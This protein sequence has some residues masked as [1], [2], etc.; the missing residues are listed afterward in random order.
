M[1]KAELLFTVL[2]LAFST[3]TECLAAE[4][5]ELTHSLYINELMQSTWGGE[6]DA[7]NEYPD[8]WVEL[9]NPSDKAVS[10]DG[11]AIGRKKNFYQCY[12]LPKAIIPAHGYIVIYCDK[13]NRNVQ[14]STSYY[15]IHTDFCLTNAKEG[16]IYLYDKGQNL[17][18]AVDI[19]VMPA[20]N[21]AYGRRADGTDDWGY[22]L[23]ATPCEKNRGGFAKMI[24]PEPEISGTSRV[25]EEKSGSSK[26]INVTISVPKDAPSDAV[27]RYTL[28]GSDPDENSPLWTKTRQ[29]FNGTTVLKARLFADR[30]L[31]SPA[32]CRVF[33][34]NGRK[35]TLPVISMVTP[36]ENLY[37]DEIGIIANNNSH[38]S[39]KRFNW[40]R[41]V[42]FDYFPKRK[43]NASV[44]QKTEIRISGAYSR[45]NAQKSFIVYADSR[46][47]SPSSDYLEAQFWPY[48][49]PDMT[50]SPSIALRCSGN[51]FNNSHM[52]DGVSQMI[53][54]FNTELDW[55]GFQ[56]ACVYINGKY[57]GILNIRERGNEDNVWMHH[58]GLKDIT[59]LENGE[60]KRG[61]YSLYQE[62]K[63]FYK[64]T[65]HTLQE[66][67]ERMD[68]VEYTNMMMANIYMSN[69]DFP[70]NNLVMWRPME[71]GGKWRW[72]LK[73]VDRSFGIWGHSYNEQY[74][75]WVLRDPE[76][77]IGGETSNSAD[78]TRLFRRLMA[79]PEYRN[80]FLDRFTVYLGDFLISDYINEIIDWAK[81]E[82]DA[83]MPYH[84][85]LYQSWLGYDGW[86]NEINS[87]KVWASRR[88]PEMYRQLKDYFELG[89]AVYAQIN[90]ELSDAD[91]YHVT[92]NGVPLSTCM[93]DGQ[94]FSGRSYSIS[95]GY[96]DPEYEVAGWLVERNTSDG[97]TSRETVLT[98]DLSIVP[99]KNDVNISI[100]AIKVATGVDPMEDDIREAERV[101][102]YNAFGVASD[103]PFDGMNIVR[104]I[105]SDGSSVSRK[106]L[107]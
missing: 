4:T 18:D 77:I 29:S 37:D 78:A 26:V 1:K 101:I 66:Y 74:L 20:P 86:K 91:S 34:F 105:Y 73:D 72:I 38:D 9:Y 50:L 89:T 8:S 62:F 25:V 100:S 13:E 5:E 61:D 10:L 33:I 46:F 15:E 56:P 23:T 60:L 58:D 3:A 49:N 47:G 14:F 67:E 82:M 31:S 35:L 28:D 106:V 97:K 6:I 39:D 87:M 17:V 98:P 2:V 75:R 94:L 65:N 92:V 96:E 84:R 30:C 76:D 40:R 63:D 54:G 81:N 90:T 43:N 71:D 42:D 11:Y 22:M 102:Y 19:P 103:T 93:F 21:V 69:T 88:T 107:K 7:L 99:N 41:P 27:I 64:G 36:E 95:A 53:F 83:E 48:T 70:G 79:I 52:R 24:L 68:I 45:E 16:H 85:N 51:D 12:E 55:Q 57:Y 32:A 80:L 44:T 104:S 59:L